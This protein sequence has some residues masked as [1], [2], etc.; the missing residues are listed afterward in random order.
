MKID[1]IDIDR[2]VESTKKLLKEDKSTSPALLAS[3]ELILLVVS[4]LANRLGLNSKNSSKPPSTDPNREKKAKS[5]SNKPPGGQ[6]GRE[7]KTLS[8]FDEPDVVTDIPVDRQQLP[9]GN[10]R[11]AGVQ[12][13]QVVDIEI[14]R[15]I[16]EYRAQVLVDEK[17]KK[18]VAPFPEGVNSPIQYG[19]SVKAHA[20]YLSQ[21]QL[22]PYKRIEEYFADQLD[23]PISAGTVFNF[24]QAATDLVK[25]TGAENKIKVA[26]QNSYVVHVDETGINI[27][28][29]RQWLH[30]ASSL[31]WTYFHAHDK[32][33]KEAM[34]DAGILPEFRGILCH[35]HWKPYYKYVLCQHSLCNAHHLRELERAWA[36]DKQQWAQK[37]GK[38]L[39]K[40][41]DDVKDSGGK[42]APGEARIAREQYREILLNGDKECPPPDEK[43]RPKGKRGRLKRT[44]ARALL[45]RLREYEDD[46]VR[47]TEISEVPF[48]NN[49]GENDIRMTKVQQKISGCFRSQNGA[50]MFCLLRSYISSCR[51]Q[52]VSASDALRLLFEGRLPEI[53]D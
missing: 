28:G 8:Q 44:K 5:N 50:D 46:V 23:I 48:T 30:C 24:N 21:Y 37:M 15:V 18:F 7:G 31:T 33:G 43:D 25:Q 47:F 51:K 17:G 12:R 42:L 40:L 34:D 27:N 11:D 2:V 22:L 16:K 41:C 36:Q 49:Q 26:I 20:V 29:K 4:L 1:D 13:R 3:I 35:D 10:Y 32:R 9:P 6:K 38:L 53:F 19:N 14:S 39:K 52:D 45:E